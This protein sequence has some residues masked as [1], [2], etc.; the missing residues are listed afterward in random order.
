MLR[1][2]STGTSV[3][4]ISVAGQAGCQRVLQVVA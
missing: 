4:G 2:M 3:L 1:N